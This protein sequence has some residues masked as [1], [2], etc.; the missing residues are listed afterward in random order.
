[1]AARADAQQGGWE[2]SVVPYF[3]PTAVDGEMTAGPRTV[4]VFLRFSDATDHLAG[5]F[6]FHG[7]AEKGR[8]GVLTDL[9][10]IRLS[11][12]TLFTILNARVAGQAKLDSVAFELGGSYLLHAP[13]Q[14]RLIGGLRTYTLA[15]KLTF[16]S[17]NFETSPIDTSQTSA[18]AFIGLTARPRLGEKWTLIA[19][20]DIGGGNADVTWSALLGLD[21]R[22]A[23]WA[24]VEF[25]YKALGI[26]ITTDDEDRI[27]SDYDMT[28][29]GPIVGFRLH[30]GG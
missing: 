26:H 21:Y 27:V 7:E 30:W 5:A 4:P 20:G 23:S 12:A 1:M 24:G 28:H 9:S 15:P 22:L 13:S 29:Y 18:N 2:L 16:S 19:R 8:W 11:T 3:N 17:I 25:G 10:F 14:V 6:S